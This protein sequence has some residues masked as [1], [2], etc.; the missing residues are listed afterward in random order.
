MVKRIMAVLVGTV[1][2]VVMDPLIA[3]LLT[4]DLTFGISASVLAGAIITSLIVEKHG[5]FYGLVVGIIN[6][7]ITLGL[8]YWFSP[9]A[10]FYEKG[11]SMADV[12]VR[13]MVLSLVFGVVGV[14][15]GGSLR[16]KTRTGQ[17]S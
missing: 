9:P 5:W 16:K 2:M 13:P 15:L 3:R 7:C 1:A 11:Y 4:R 10:S 6:C 8:F 14:A 12:V 17:P